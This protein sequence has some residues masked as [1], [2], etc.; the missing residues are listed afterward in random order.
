MSKHY[1]YSKNV[2]KDIKTISIKTCLISE[3]IDPISAH[4]MN[5]LFLLTQ[6]QICMHALRKAFLNIII[7]IKNY[8]FV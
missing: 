5:F 7:L 6:T 4:L 8:R 1:F 3:L 2:V